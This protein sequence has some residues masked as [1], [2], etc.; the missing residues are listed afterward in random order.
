MK[1]ILKRLSFLLVFFA[2][3]LGA[4]SPKVENLE[5]KEGLAI[6]DKLK[7][8]NKG[9]KEAN[10]NE[11]KSNEEKIDKDG[12]YYYL[13]DLVLYLKTYGKLPKNYITKKEATELGWEKEKGNLWE[14]TDKAVI[15]G[16]RFGNREKKLPVKAKRKYFEADVNYNGGFRGSERIIFSNDGLIFYTDDHYNTFTDLSN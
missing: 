7:E 8:E 14:V 13:D 12:A 4:C 2:L 6:E 3:I 5:E 10:K 16:D 15:G 1:S 11:K 9:Q